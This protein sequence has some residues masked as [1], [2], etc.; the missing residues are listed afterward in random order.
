[1]AVQCGDHQ[2]QDVGR[3]S[4]SDSFQPA[5]AALQIVGDHPAGRRSSRWFDMSSSFDVFGT[6]ELCTWKVEP[7]VCWFQT[8]N[9]LIGEKL[10]QR[11]RAK[12]VLFTFG[13]RYFRVFEEKIAPSRARQV[14]TRLS[15]YLSPCNTGPSHLT[16]LRSRSAVDNRVQMTGHPST[17][18]RNKPNLLAA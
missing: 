2:A 9:P 5:N 18:R 17:N 8:T 11:A 3:I 16:V 12:V 15:R 6:T 1:V 14:V 4:S 10:A 7:R 13:D